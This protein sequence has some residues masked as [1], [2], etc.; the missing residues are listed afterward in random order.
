MGLVEA[1][2][3]GIGT[4]I[5]AGIFILPGIAAKRAGPAAFLAFFLGGIVAAL[6]ALS[7]S[8]LS[9]G[10]PKS[11]GSY[12]FVM[13]A[14]GPLFGSIVGWG[15][16]MGLMFASAFYM[17]GFGEYF[18]F[19]FPI[20]NRT[21][22]ALLM[23]FVL[24]SINY[25]G[26]KE[27]GRFQDFIVIGLLGILVIFIG[28]GLTKV[29][30]TLQTPL[31]PNGWG[32]V[33]STTALIFVAFLG[34]E[35]ITTVAEEIREPE[36]NLP[37]AIL[38][39]VA[40]VT[41]FYMLILFV[42]TGIISYQ[43]LG[44]DATPIAKVAG[45]LMGTGGV[46][47]LVLASWFATISSANASI[48]SASRVNFAMGR[49]RLVSDWLNKIHRQFLTPYRSIMVS[50]GIIL[51]LILVGNIE[52]LAKVASFAFLVSYILVHIGCILLRESDTDWYN[53]T[54]KVPGYPIVPIAG[55]LSCFF[56]LTLMGSTV[57]LIGLGMIFF[58]VVWYFSWAKEQTVVE[59]VIDQ[60]LAN[61]TGNGVYRILVP[62]ANPA[63]EEEKLK[64]AATI[65]R[66][67]KGEVLALNVMEIPAQTP[68]EVGRKLY[69]EREKEQETILKK[70][71]KRAE[72]I[73]VPVKTKHVISHNISKAIVDTA[74]ARH[75]NLILAGWKGKVKS[76]RVI[77]SV[78]G[79]V[80][81][82]STVNVAVLKSRGLKD[83]KKILLPYRGGPHGRVCLDL[84]R[85]LMRAS[86]AKLTVIKVLPKGSVKKEAK[87]LQEVLKQDFDEFQERID[88]QV[89]KG[90]DIVGNIAIKSREY[91][92]VVIGASNE[93]KLKRFL[94][95]SIPDG[96]ANKAYCS[97][98]MVK[99]VEPEKPTLIG[100]IIRFLK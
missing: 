92:L 88:T 55:A 99:G 93:W 50:G 32:S 37:I 4:M 3:L 62:M 26:A 34:F 84:V 56:L 100:R 7:L 8:E 90:K 68:L 29:N 63:H 79:E 9:T 25:I 66:A 48:L 54:F 64:I 65:N 35:V 31:V 81:R 12:Y 24:I 20:L 83:L 21:V 80:I 19:L 75:C 36:K 77:G 78:V 5:G 97:V 14:L 57:Q 30:M 27:T 69:I 41:V 13:R 23:C 72:T 11:G 2:T 61:I 70:V 22:V 39:S 73:G 28:F 85:D 71:A 47:L 76:S 95:G 1:L 38:G 67:R 6:T 86:D 96:T 74:K 46:L 17:I 51:G 10:M 82:K 98:M 53:P 49:D 60:A 42:A 91:D 94:F 44:L 87:A 33:A 58:G 59:G 15:M 40:I 43:K 89:F 45:V 16:W 18:V 52:V